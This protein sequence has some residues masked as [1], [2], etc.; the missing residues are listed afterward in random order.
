MAGDAQAF[1]IVEPGRGELRTEP[2]PL[3]LAGEVVVDALYSGVS[4]GTEALVFLGRVPASEQQRMRAPFQVGEFPG[5]VKYGYCNVGLVVAGDAAWVGRTVFCLFPHQTR[6]VVPAASVHAVPADVPARRAVLAANMET[7]LNGVWDAGVLPGD[8]VAVVG[9]GAVGC[10]VAWLASRIAGCDVELV[11]VNPGRRR[12]AD[13]LG[14]AFADPGNARRD[15]DVVV[16][17]SA[18]A[19][20]LATALHLAGVEST[21]LELSWYGAQDV[22][23]PLGEAF[24]ARRLTLKSSQVGRVAPV[25]RARWSHARRLGLA[26]SLL[27]EPALDVLVT[28]ECAFAELPGVMPALASGALDTVCHAVRYPSS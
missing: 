11:D 2:L 24:H 19:A 5:P 28:G 23:V 26:L 1:W 14:L 18:T 4:R 15:A 22:S 13:A 16:H 21:V 17:A 12:M 7:A 8:R 6:Y 9:G 3:P 20:G 25:Q 27:R 10:L